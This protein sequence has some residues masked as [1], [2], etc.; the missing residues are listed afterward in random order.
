[1]EPEDTEELEEP[2]Y[3]GPIRY[4]LGI[5][6]I[7]LLIVWLIPYYSVKLDPEP[8][9]VPGLGEVLPENMEIDETNR[10]EVRL[11]MVK[12]EDPAIK[13]VAD[14]I[15]SISC[16]SSRICYAKA[17]FY[18]VRDNFQYVNDPTAYEYVKTAKQSLVSGNGDCDD[19]SVL[20]AS[21]LDAIGVRTRFVFVPGHVYIQA[22][23]PEA[24]NRYKEEGEWV[25]MDA[26]CSYCE[27]GEISWQSSGEERRFLG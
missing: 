27:F 21:L 25:N 15:V 4:I 1:M 5:F 22:Y 24:L 14:K 18:F 8:G 13:T 20:L 26:T 9:R 23:L 11:D 7:L 6:L 2:W 19:A 12:G 10:Q 16:D 17:I 3:K